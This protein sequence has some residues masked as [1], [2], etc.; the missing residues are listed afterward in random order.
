MTKQE[1]IDS[2][3]ERLMFL[4]ERLG[5]KNVSYVVADHVCDWLRWMLDDS[6]EL[7]DELYEEQV[8]TS[9]LLRAC[10]S[11]LNHSDCTFCKT[12]FER[13]PECA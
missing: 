3:R 7:Y 13:H 5:D 1:K 2:L 11:L 4:H 6:T 10:A 8:A 12:W 9:P